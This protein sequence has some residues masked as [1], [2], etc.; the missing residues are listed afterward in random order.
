MKNNPAAA[1]HVALSAV[2]RRSF[3]RGLGVAL[4]LPLAS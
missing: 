4:G 3:L 2:G 1:P